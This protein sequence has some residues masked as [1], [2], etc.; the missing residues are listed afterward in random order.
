[1]FVCECGSADGS[2][3]RFLEMVED[4]LDVL[5]LGKFNPSSFAVPSDMYSEDV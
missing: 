5:L 3:I 1:M 4:L 2:D